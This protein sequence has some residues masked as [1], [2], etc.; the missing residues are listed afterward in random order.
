MAAGSTRLSD[1]TSGDFPLD[2]DGVW[3]EVYARPGGRRPALFLDRDGVIVEETGYLRR[4][5]DIALIPGAAAAIA[6][7]NARGVPVVIVTN[8]A[9]IG[10]GMFGWDVFRTVQQTINQ[11]LAREDAH[12]DAVYAAPHHS[13]GVGEFAHPNHP[14]RKPNPGML[15]RAAAALDIDLAASWLA[16]D[17]LSDME[18]AKNAG[19]A[20]GLHVLTGHGRSERD[21]ILQWR[22]DNSFDVR[23]GGSL[24]EAMQLSILAS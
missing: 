3:C 1:V 5:E 15:L 10:R 18:A 7:A 14:A 19:L 20:G 21:R 16:G 22:T 13:E 23:L 4:V 9:G 24:I 17:K 2:Q 11:R 6:N 8:Q 12:I